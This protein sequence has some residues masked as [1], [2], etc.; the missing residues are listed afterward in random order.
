MGRHHILMLG[1]TGSGKTYIVK[2]VARLLQV[3]V[4]FV[5]ANSLVEVGYRGQSVDSIVK[6]LL[7]RADGNP[8]LAEKA[9][10][11]LTRSTR[12]GV[13]IPVARGMSVAREFRTRC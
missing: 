2:T 4:S 12:S 10:S 1:P 8:R 13:R 6:R 9:S 7:D 5:S 3:P 11:S